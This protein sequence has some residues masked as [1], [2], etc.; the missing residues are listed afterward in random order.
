[1]L[2]Q[3]PRGRRGRLGKPLENS[4]VEPTGWDCQGREVTLKGGAGLGLSQPAKELRD[5]TM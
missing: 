5:S 4:G 3:V 2:T 1:M